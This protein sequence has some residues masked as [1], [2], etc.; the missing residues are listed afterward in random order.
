MHDAVAPALSAANIKLRASE[1]ATPDVDGDGEGVTR[2]AVA[3]ALSAANVEVG[4]IEPHCAE[5]SV[6]AELVG[7]YRGV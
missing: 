6:V 1:L 3:P 5:H 2:D 4:S 7:E